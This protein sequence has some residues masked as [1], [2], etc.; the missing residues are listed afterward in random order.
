MPQTVTTSAARRHLGLPEG[1]KTQAKADLRNPEIEPDW[2]A[3]VGSAL[4]RA[5]E[6][7]G[8]SSKVAAGKVGVDDG[9]FGRWLSGSERAQ[10]DRIWKVEEL[11]QPLVIAM[12]ERAGLG[13]RVRTVVTLQQRLGGNRP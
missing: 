5:I 2:R 4:Q 10:F 1:K 7:L 9:Q 6:L 11:R 8:W 12:A 3:I 13:V